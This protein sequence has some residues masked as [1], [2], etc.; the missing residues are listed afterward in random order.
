MTKKTKR[1]K[2]A[3]VFS[4]KNYGRN[5]SFLFATLM[6]TN[7]YTYKS[8]KQNERQVLVSSSSLH[9]QDS[10]HLYTLALEVRFCQQKKCNML[11]KSLLS[12]YVIGTFDQIDLGKSFS[13]I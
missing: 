9:L 4:M 13:F 11:I 12:V 5:V 6:K 8:E 3:H 2:K 7:A 1:Q 10:Q